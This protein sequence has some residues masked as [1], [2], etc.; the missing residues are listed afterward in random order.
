MSQDLQIIRLQVRSVDCLLDVEGSP[1]IGPRI[2]PEVAQTLYHDAE[3]FGGKNRFRIEVGVPPTET[4]RISEVTL[5]IH[6]HFHTQE[7]DASSELRETFSNGRI[8]LFFAMLVVAALVIISEWMQ[9]FGQ[10][11]LYTLLGESLII[12]AWV[13]LWMPADM[14]LFSHLPIRRRRNIARAL[15]RAEIILVP[16]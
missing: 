11:R 13:T 4:S 9:A 5:A 12:I 14:L 2:H 10:G 6:T 8:S 3:E 15:S 1:L 7:R 16:L